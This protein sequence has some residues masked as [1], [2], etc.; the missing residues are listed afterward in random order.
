MLENFEVDLEEDI[1][2]EYTEFGEEIP[3]SLRRRNEKEQPK[4]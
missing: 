4:D 2:K 1:D 3:K